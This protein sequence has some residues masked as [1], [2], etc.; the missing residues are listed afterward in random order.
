MSKDLCKNNRQVSQPDPSVSSALIPDTQAVSRFLEDVADQI[1]YRPLR[2]AIQAELQDHIE[3]RA[4][5]YVSQGMSQEQ[6]RIQAVQDMGDAI[7]IGTELNAAHQLCPCPG[8]LLLSALMLGL[9]MLFSGFFQWSPEQSAGSFL[10]YL[11]GF[12][13][14]LLVVWKGYPLFVRHWRLPLL[15]AAA[16]LVLNLLGRFLAAHGLFYS[17]LL[18]NPGYQHFARLLIAPVGI[19]ILYR[20]RH[21]GKA[22]MTS[23]LGL[24][25]FWLLFQMLCPDYG[26][27][28]ASVAAL[29]SL[30]VTVCLLIRRDCFSFRKLRLYAVSLA[31]FLLM[32]SSTV[33]SAPQYIQEFL[34]P[35]TRVHCTW[36]DSYNNILIQDLLSRTPL[37]G[38]IQLTQAELMDY[39][40]GTWYFASRDP[41]QI[42]ISAVGLSSEQEQTAFEAEVKRIR[43]AGGH[44]RYIHF[45]EETVTLW[46]ILPQ[47]YHNNY[48]IAV[49]ILQYGWAAGLA[50]CG[51]I[52]LFYL[53]L[54]RC[55][56]HIGGRLA[57][58]LAMVCGQCL[59]WQTVLYVL[60]NFGHQYASFPTLPLVSEGRI[61]L[62]FNMI[63][64]G[65]LISAYRYHQ[66]ETEPIL[67][68]RAP[69]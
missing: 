36:D 38:G 44:P 6:A 7:S 67:G 5:A 13:F 31:A 3:D 32:G 8:L 28:S 66:V 47:H 16:F 26:M 58:G 45:T 37:L 68:R 52:A 64:L 4:D 39:G 34:F 29:L 17:R 30:F 46:D 61:S 55:I 23:V 41:L 9:G 57:Y 33:L 22:L 18:N 50:L 62:F 27:Q 65:F 35:D 48:V 12:L 56:R 21:T 60:G 1:S 51:V 63:F 59:L 20:F 2:P 11:P 24:A 40:T 43:E 54:F 42:G 53:L 14:F 49:L 25:G 19:L 15:A 10:Y 69:V